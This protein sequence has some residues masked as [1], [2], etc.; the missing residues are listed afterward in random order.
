MRRF[1]YRFCVLIVVLFLFAPGAGAYYAGDASGGRPGDYL[2]SLSADAA[3]AAVG[4]SGSAF[5]GRLSGIYLN[6]ASLCHLKKDELTVFYRPLYDGGNYYFI[7]GGYELGPVSRLPGVS[8]IGVTVAGTES[9]AAEK[10]TLL[11]DIQG[12]FY[13]KEQSLI[14]SFAYPVKDKLATGVNMKVL[15]QSMDGYRAS[16][17]GADAGIIY[18]LKSSNL[19]FCVQN[20]APPSLKLKDHAERYP[21]NL[22]FGAVTEFDNG[23]IKP[24]AD[25]IISGSGKAK[26]SL[27][28]AGCSYLIS[29]VFS[30]SAGLNYKEFSIC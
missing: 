27:W 26:S 9:A 6:P 7:G 4:G 10:T 25:V 22:I 24:S 3:Q 15:T 19:S 29:P 18:F 28:K 1:I 8:Y 11:R 5:R 21:R 2:L 12:S 23:K 16:S 14:F 17:F 20:L 30:L 13:N